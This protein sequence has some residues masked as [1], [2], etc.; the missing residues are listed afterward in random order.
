MF[1][2]KTLQALFITGTLGAGLFAQSSTALAAPLKTAPA[3]IANVTVDLQPE[4][5]AV[6][7]NTSL[8]YST[9]RTHNTVTV[10]DGK[11]NQVT[12]NI[13]LGGQPHALAVLTALNRVYATSISSTGF[14]SLAV[15]D[16][17]TNSVM[18]YL[19]IGFEASPAA[20]AV[21]QNTGRVYVTAPGLKTVA[22]ID[23]LSNSIVD[24]IHGFL[25]PADIAVNSTT[26]RVYVTNLDYDT[27]SVIDGASDNFAGNAIKVGNG[28]AAAVAVN[29]A[30]NRIYVGTNGA[31]A[32]VDGNSNS[33]VA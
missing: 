21:N 22:V 12:G 20:V 2:R 29:P 15:I 27:L 13:L 23:G 7:P 1:T 16:A 8:I 30:T 14:G 28:I 19:P 10:V 9:G 5:V 25:E 17:S 32:V 11:T 26:N 4:G 24:M 6:N 31:V 18:T 3:V 33:L